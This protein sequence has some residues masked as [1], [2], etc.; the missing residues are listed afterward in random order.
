MG[1]APRPD[2]IG[3]PVRFR[4][5][6]LLLYSRS[7][8]R[9]EPRSRTCTRKEPT[10][11]ATDP[12]IPS[13][14]EES[15]RKMTAISAIMQEGGDSFSADDMRLLRDAFASGPSSDDFMEQ[16]IE[17]YRNGDAEDAEDEG[18]DEI[19]LNQLDW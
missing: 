18:E 9:A 10:V 5:A 19:G 14:D 17:S 15:I 6:P 3:N 8:L 1:S 2:T 11:N 16:F 12:D 13:E 7:E 4:R